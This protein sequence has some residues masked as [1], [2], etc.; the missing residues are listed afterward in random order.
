MLFPSE[1]VSIRGFCSILALRQDPLCFP[2]DWDLRC[3]GKAEHLVPSDVTCT[4]ITAL[5]YDL[6]FP[7]RLHSHGT[8]PLHLAHTVL[9][10]SKSGEFLPWLVPEVPSRVTYHTGLPSIPLSF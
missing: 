6:W 10:R 3:I 4:S 9:W 8:P 5:V 1:A 7:R 2:H